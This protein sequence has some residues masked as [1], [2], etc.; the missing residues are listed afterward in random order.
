MNP[1]TPTGPAENHE[2]PEEQVPK[3]AVYETDTNAIMAE[4]TDQAKNVFSISTDAIQTNAPVEVAD[5]SNRH[6]AETVAQKVA[7]LDSPKESGES[8]PIPLSVSAIPDHSS[9]TLPALQMERSRA[10]EPVIQQSALMVDPRPLFRALWEQV[11]PLKKGDLFNPHFNDRFWMKTKKSIGEGKLG[12]KVIDG[13]L[14]IGN[15][16]GS[17]VANAGIFNYFESA[18]GNAIV[19][20]GGLG[21]KI[22]EPF[23]G[24]AGLPLLTIAGRRAYARLRYEKAVNEAYNECIDALANNV[25][26]SN[27]PTET[28]VTDFMQKH[29]NN[30]SSKDIHDFQQ[31]YRALNA[32]TAEQLATFKSRHPAP[33]VAEVNEY[34][35]GFLFGIPM[36]GKVKKW[37]E[38]F[39]KKREAG[40]RHAHQHKKSLI[41]TLEEKDLINLMAQHAH[42]KPSEVPYLGSLDRYEKYCFVRFNE[43]CKELSQKQ[44]PLSPLEQKVISLFY[45]EAIDLQTTTPEAGTAVIHKIHDVS[46]EYAK[47]LQYEH[48]KKRQMQLTAQVAGGTA[49]A[50]PVFGPAAFVMGGLFE[51]GCRIYNEFGAPKDLKFTSHGELRVTT[52]AQEHADDSEALWVR[53]IFNTKFEEADMTDDHKHWMKLMKLDEHVVHDPTIKSA[54]KLAARLQEQVMMQL[55]G[56]KF[57]P[58]VSKKEDIDKT[59]ADYK[60]ELEK[61]RELKVKLADLE[62]KKTIAEAN[63]DEAQ[64]VVDSAGASKDSKAKAEQTVKR[65]DRELQALQG[66]IKQVKLELDGDD[67]QEARSN[68][69]KKKWDD[70]VNPPTAALKLSADGKK[71]FDIHEYEKETIDEEKSR[72]EKEAKERR[73]NL[74]KKDFNQYKKDYK[75]REPDSY[76]V[77]D[78]KHTMDEAKEAFDQSKT[79]ANNQQGDPA[80]GTTHAD[81]KKKYDVISKYVSMMKEVKEAEE[82][83]DT[84]LK[85]KREKLETAFKTIREAYAYKV[86]E[87]WKEREAHGQ[88]VFKTASSVAKGGAKE[89]GKTMIAEGVQLVFE[90]GKPV[91]AAVIG[92]T[93]LILIGAGGVVTGVTSIVA[94]PYILG[95]LAV[96]GGG[97]YIYKRV[98]SLG[99]GVGDWLKKKME[100]EKKVEEKKDEKKEE[101][102]AHH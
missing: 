14:T 62:R 48:R 78:L 98:T 67:G 35:Q 79:A 32:P 15:G 86:K 49:A 8:A 57:P 64:G 18:I 58:F 91:L 76:D 82:A 66:E 71:L 11:T 27:Q 77:S 2:K 17:S 68:K 81:A 21:T 75:G 37:K 56:S 28:E 61:L 25:L 13:G 84:M 20:G 26:N 19:S 7:V 34:E 88:G 16:V 6:G 87:Q 90:S 83:L 47:L 85:G 72:K 45:V 102:P 93:A 40:V 30:P 36:A 89:A 97:K 44:G 96:Y 59:E 4:T 94:T 39:G 46:H 33:T 22:V 54:E 5:D 43:V 80:L 10:G 53:S 63:R 52:E 31:Q 69:A 70:L 1:I 24:G 100:P 12:A 38:E 29:K 74:L 99:G 51:A 65:N 95:G 73:L 60:L 3:D 55:S 92:G 9:Q 41:D 23:L 50:L 42:C 101:P